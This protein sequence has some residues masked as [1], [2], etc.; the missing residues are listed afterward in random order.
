M[1]TMSMA[2][3]ASLLLS[4][5]TAIG[6]L[7]PATAEAAPTIVNVSSRSGWVK[8]NVQPGKLHTLNAAT[9]DWTVDRRS[10][11]HV[12]ASGYQGV[13]DRNIYKGC[14]FVEN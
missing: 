2:R 14:K 12:T 9:G 10:I 6:L 11:P 1:R 5:V 13:D 4:T 3:S 8:V 7:L